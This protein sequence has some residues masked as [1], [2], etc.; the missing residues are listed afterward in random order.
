VLFASFLDLS[1]FAPVGRFSAGSKVE[2]LEEIEDEVS[3]LMDHRARIN[4]ASPRTAV[5]VPEESG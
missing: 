3:L 1:A 2:A 4:P 5:I